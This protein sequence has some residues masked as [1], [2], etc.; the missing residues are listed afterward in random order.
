MAADDNR[1]D[2]VIDQIYSAGLLLWSAS[3]LLDGEEA[4]RHVDQ[5]VA[6]LD[7]ALDL[8]RRAAW[9]GRTGPPRR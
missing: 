1:A 2:A 5:A 8:I 6:E 7:V 4:S 3:S 9:T